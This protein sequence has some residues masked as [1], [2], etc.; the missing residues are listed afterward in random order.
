M[1]CPSLKLGRRRDDHLRMLFSCLAGA[2]LL[3]VAMFAL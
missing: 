3:V 2:A 1:E